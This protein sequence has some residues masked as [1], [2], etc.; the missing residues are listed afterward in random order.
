MLRD[1]KN[2]LPR[3]S[4]DERYAHVLTALL[5][6]VGGIAFCLASYMAILW[7]NDFLKAWGITLW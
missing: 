1:G 6:L 3:Y 2:Q 5:A 4:D 7:L